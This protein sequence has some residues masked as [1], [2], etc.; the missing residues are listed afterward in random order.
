MYSR[1]E[2]T[3][4]HH[5]S[6]KEGNSLFLH[7]RIIPY[8]VNHY[9]LHGTDSCK[10]FMYWTHCIVHPVY[11]YS[12][13]VSILSSCTWGAES[14]LLL[15]KTF[16]AIYHNCTLKICWDFSSSL[17]R[18][19]SPGYKL[20][21]VWMLMW[22]FNCFQVLYISTIKVLKIKAQHICTKINTY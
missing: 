17:F 12:L 3:K 4:A 19:F 14:N 21:Y 20:C 18:G 13:L 5:N 16:S 9:I 2:E 7:G 1:I 8:A 15:Y 11:L 22:L 10:L 6:P